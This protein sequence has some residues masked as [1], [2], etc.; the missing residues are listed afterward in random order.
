EQAVD[1]VRPLRPRLLDTGPAPGADAGGRDR[2]TAL[3]AIGRVALAIDARALRRLL[4]IAVAPAIGRF[5][6]A[7]AAI[8]IAIVPAA[9]GLAACRLRVAA[10]GARPFLPLVVRLGAGRILRVAGAADDLAVFV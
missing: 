7:I 4:I 8:L 3:D 5:G 9:I 6:I 1:Q 10:L 2:P